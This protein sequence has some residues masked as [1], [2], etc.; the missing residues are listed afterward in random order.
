M[1]RLCSEININGSQNWELTA[2][3]N[4]V[5]DEDINTL[6]DT[7]TIT[8]PK[9]V[10][11]E[12]TTLNENLPI[13]RGDKITVKLGYD[14]ALKTRFTGFIRS[15]D[16]RY[17]VTIKCEDSMFLLKTV[18]AK[19]NSYKNAMLKQVVNDLLDGTGIQFELIDKDV[20]LGQYRVTQATVA[21]ELNELKQQFLLKSYFR[22]IGEKSILYVGLTYPF[23]NRNKVLFMTGKN[24]IS[25]DFEFRQ[26]EDIKIKIEATSLDRKNK[27]I[28][29][30][31]G[32]KTGD[33]IKINIPDLTETELKEFGLK[34]LERNKKTGLK[35]SFKTFGEP[36]VNKCDI[37][38]I[39]SSDLRIGTYLIQKIETEFGMNGYRQ[40]ITI[41]EP[42]ELIKN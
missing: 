8:I 12:N 42:L 7:C 22:T 17:P 16:I 2:V 37:I 9:K 32:D 6:T 1:L 34:V 33:I 5:I 35:G 14:D 23:D 36:L 18:K 31:L 11:F 26:T 27:K 39:H 24:I 4:V 29:L 40:N 10:H 21:Q 3:N 15:V 41:G 13:K 19:P 38:E 25:E 28:Y 30:E 20:R